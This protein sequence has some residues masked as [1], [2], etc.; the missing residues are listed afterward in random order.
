MNQAG[1]YK[2]DSILL[3]AP[4]GT[5]DIKTLMVEL[6]V[7]ESIHTNAM[8]GNI[9]I[10]DTNNHIQNMPIIGQELLEFKFG[11]DDNPDNESIDFTRHKARIYKVSD[12]VRTAERQ[13]VYTL[14]FTTQEAIQNQQT[15]C[16]QAYEGTTDEIVANI[17]LNVLKTKKSIATENSSQGGKLLGNHSTPFDFITKMLT[18]RSCSAMFDA[19]GYLFYENHRGY[20]F[21]SYKNHTHRTPGNERTVQ[22]SYIVQPSKRNSTI[23]EDMKSVLEYRIMK[24]QDVMAAI[25]TGLTASTNYNYDFTNKSFSVLFNNYMENFTQEVHTTIGKNIG[26][27]FTMTP[28]TN[29]GDTLF[30]KNDSKIMITTKDVALHSQKKGDGKYDNHTGKTQQRNHDRLQ[31]DQIAAKCTVFGNSNL[32]AGDIIHLRVPSYE[33]LDKTSTRIHDAFLSGRWL[34]TNV[35]HT[36]NSTR[37]TT[38]FDCV[39]DSVEQPYTSTDQTILQNVDNE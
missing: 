32:A 2:L 29:N 22:E 13:Q 28:E 25:N 9:V 35:V 16:K 17:L 21:R 33:P 12:Q 19:Q 38:T 4:T 6:N 11:T 15:A 5:I 24:N 31:H 14:H 26:S 36:L 1:D 3:H 27:L 37:Y 7:Y 39:R 30:D 23:A 10:A 8:Y 20:N 18:K 34:L